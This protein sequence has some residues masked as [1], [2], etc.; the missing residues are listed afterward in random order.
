MCRHAHALQIS[1]KQRAKK[2][3]KCRELEEDLAEERKVQDYL[4]A[5]AACPAKGS[6]AP[7]N[8]GTRHRHADMTCTVPGG[9]VVS[10]SAAVGQPGQPAEL[11]KAS[12]PCT[13]GLWL[14]AEKATCPAPLN[15]DN[16]EFRDLPGSPH[17]PLSKDACQ[18]LFGNSSVLEGDT[19]RSVAPPTT[20]GGRREGAFT[21]AAVAEGAMGQGALT[22]AEAGAVDK[23]RGQR[24]VP[25]AALAGERSNDAVSPTAKLPA[26]LAEVQREQ[27]RM[28]GEFSGHLLLLSKQRDTTMRELQQL[29]VCNL[30]S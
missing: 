14:S 29:K 15:L 22:A 9:I 24:A 27:A 26:L 6:T 2:E 10:T 12:D 8:S 20:L 5:Q 19:C 13:G 1:E 7:S 18:G 3:Q 25:A 17:K 21:A 23:G 30:S 16:S 4:A 11:W 28:Q